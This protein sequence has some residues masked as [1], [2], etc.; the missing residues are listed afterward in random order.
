MEDTV[1]YV[2]APADLPLH[3]ANL[4]R[5]LAL[6]PTRILPNHGSP[7]VI[8]AGGYS[9]GLIAATQ[10]Y[11]DFLLRVRDDPSLAEL[12]LRQ[13]VDAAGNADVH[14]HAPYERVHRSN[15]DAVSNEEPPR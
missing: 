8:A 12:T 5:L 14:Y 4:G 2:D 6:Q 1:T 13:V 7:E 11:I 10:D 9:A 15:I 3:R